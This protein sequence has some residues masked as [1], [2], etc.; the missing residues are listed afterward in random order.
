MASLDAG[1]RDKIFSHFGRSM[2]ARHLPQR[3][4][5]NFDLNDSRPTQSEGGEVVGILGAGVGGLYTALM[6]ESLGIPFE[7]LEASDRVG[8]RLYTHK[9]TGEQAGKYDYYDVGAMRFP[10]PK[11]D[12]KGDYLP[13]VMQR[14]GKLFKYI[15]MQDKLI[16]YYFKSDGRPG[17][18]YFN[19]VRARIGDNNS[20]NA[21]DLGINSTLIEL[22]VSNIVNDVVGPFAKML[23]DD[24][25][26]HT[27]TGWDV[28]MRNDVYSTRA[29]MSFKYIPSASFG[30]VDGTTGPSAR[31]LEAIAFG[32]AG[33]GVVDWKC[34]DG[35]SHVLPETMVTY[36]ENKL[37]ND[38]FLVKNTRVT[39]IGLESDAD[40]SPMVVVAGG[41]ERKY[42]HVIS[43]LPLP[44]LRTIDL[45]GSKL[46]LIQENGLRQCQYGPSIK[47]GMLFSE[48]WWTTGNDKDGEPIKIVGGQSYTDL[49]IRTVVYPSY[50]AYTDEPSRTL[51]ASYCWTNDAERLGS[52]IGTGAPTYEAQL[53]TLVLNNLALVH[54]VTYDY[55]KSRLWS[56]HSWDWNHD[57]LTMGAFAFF[58]PG[59]F[60]D[61]Y[62]SLNKPAANDKLHFAGEALSIRHAWVVG[63]LDSAWRA[64]YDYLFFSDPTKIEKFFELWGTNAEW[65]E[66]VDTLIPLPPSQR[67]QHSLLERY[68]RHTKPAA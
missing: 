25:K 37:G 33:D 11:T 49:P 66:E 55:L 10:L 46:S 62:S 39:S 45:S 48:P 7:I 54:N 23:Y 44:V 4:A 6:L 52:L 50:G 59:N 31:L 51:I 16:P 18:Q 57:P 26:N 43:T 41:K 30:A 28:M 12:E 68:V 13:G 3:H 56:M 36:L 22:G 58:G 40:D 63:A 19:G 34:I 29:Y 5:G 21:P 15:D 65:F 67:R 32:E 42:S 9:F 2:I 60:E 64:V 27:T 24:L 38:N 14:V 8:G 47:I 61:M 35:G 1:T 20:F 53:E 17:F